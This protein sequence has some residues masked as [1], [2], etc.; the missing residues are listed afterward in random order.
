MLCFSHQ[1]PLAVSIALYPLPAATANHSPLHTACCPQASVFGYDDILRRLWPFLQR[2]RAARAC[3]PSLRAF[4]VSADVSRAFDSVDIGRLL[5]LALPLLREP[6][7]TVVRCAGKGRGWCGGLGC[8]G[9]C[10]GGPA[11]AVISPCSACVCWVGFG[12]GGC[13]RGAEGST[14]EKLPHDVFCQS[15]GR[16]ARICSPH[17]KRLIN[18]K[19]WAVKVGVG[20][21]GHM[22]SSQIVGCT[23][24]VVPW[25]S[26]PLMAPARPPG[27]AVLCLLITTISSSCTEVLIL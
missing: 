17:T 22:P 7:Y 19:F 24:Q 11:H 2:F 27:C 18:D 25:V 12:L 20:G 4:L 9:V 21:W 5:E 23:C 6:G 3:D 8:A 13:A 1:Q 26:C 15:S 14:P 16:C 10:W